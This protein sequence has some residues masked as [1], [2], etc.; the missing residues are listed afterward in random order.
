MLLFEKLSQLGGQLLLGSVTAY[1]KEILSL[2]D[3]HKKQVEKMGIDIRLNEEVTPEIVRTVNPDVVVLCTGS[4][5]V[6]PPLPGIDK[7]IVL[8][9]PEILNGN[10]PAKRKTV[11]LGGGATGCEVAHHLAEHGCPV[12]IVEQLPKIAGQMESITRKVLLKQLRDK[13]VQFLTGKRLSRIE[14]HGVC[15]VSEDGTETFIETEAVVIAIGNRPDNRL[16]GQIATMGIPIHQIGDCLEPRSA[17]AAI[18]E[19]A[20]IGRAI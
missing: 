14:D 15:V 13:K 1:K 7:S 8:S 10:A 6:R 9:L 19:A 11:V 4:I 5:P 17:K 18:S 12:T 16:Y 3:Y 20:E 2:I